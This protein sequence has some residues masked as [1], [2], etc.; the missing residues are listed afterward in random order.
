MN[1]FDSGSDY[2][3]HRPS[4]PDELPGLLAELPAHRT[5]ALDVG[6]G[7]GQLTAKLGAHFEQVL[8]V[9]PSESQVANATGPDNA[10]FEVG[11]ASQLPAADNSVDL[12]TV[13]QAVHWFPDLDAFYDESRRVA[14][15]GAA[16][17]LISYGLCHLEGLNEMYQDFYWGD[18]HRHWEPERRHVENQLADIAFPFERI[19]IESP[20]IV[21]D[22]TLEQFIGYLGTW[23]ALKSPGAPEEAEAFQA[24]L[25][26]AWGDGSLLRRVTW[27]LTVL[28]G[29]I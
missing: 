18:F 7:T 3:A 23:S 5:C 21:R 26:R 10:R 2:A 19:G 25:A 13:A 27:P 9:D 8:G 29:R 14:A 15:P 11:T 20:D 24:K 6:C 16:I 17:A 12:I 4:Y 22:L 28:A 1:L